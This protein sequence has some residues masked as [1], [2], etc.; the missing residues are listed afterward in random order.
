VVWGPSGQWWV[1]CDQVRG[2]LGWVWAFMSL[3]R[4]FLS[5]AV[6]VSG[7]GPKAWVKPWVFP[8]RSRLMSHLGCPAVVASC[9]IVFVSWG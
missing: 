6:V 5:C 3:M 7:L 1:S 2:G 4:S 9:P 8:T